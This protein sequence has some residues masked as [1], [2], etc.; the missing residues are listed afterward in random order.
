MSSIASVER[1]QHEAEQASTA[2]RR[3]PH[4][5]TYSRKWAAALFLVDLTLF[6]ASAYLAHLLA[7]RVWHTPNVAKQVTGAAIIIALWMVMFQ[8]LGLYRRTYAFRMRDELYYT[9]A[10]LSLGA[11]PQLLVFTVAPHISTSRVGALLTLALS[12]P[13]VGSGRAVM[14]GLRGLRIFKRASRIAFIG[15][16]HRTAEAVASIE[17]PAGPAP[18]VIAVED[19]NSTLRGEHGQ[20]IR[21][22]ESLEWFAQAMRSGCGTL[23]F[24]EIIDPQLLPHLLDVAARYR[25]RV[26]FAPPR[27]KWE[28]YSLSLEA[29]GSQALIVASPLNA[30]TPSARLT[31]RAIDVALAA[32]ALIVFAP[33]M[34]VCAIAVYL[35]SGA[36][37]LYRQERIGMDGKPFAILKFRSMAL[38][39]EKTTGA[40]WVREND[41]R[42]TRV[43]AIL[44]RL[45]F[46]ELPQ[47]FNVLRGEMSLVGP[48]PERP[49]F[50]EEFRKRFP[51]YDERHLVPPG[52]T[53]WSHVHM[54]R[55]VHEDDIGERLQYDL[56][57]VEQW[58]VWLDAAILFKT[59]VEFLFHKS[60]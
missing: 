7:Q 21:R 33:L 50:V 34:A 38:D 59:A 54:Q 13:M 25:L 44:R 9:I 56:R 46:D 12:I 24:T 5:I 29:N 26:A 32:V 49:V 45:S 4:A 42:R 57:Y 1:H 39:A 16:P 40:I 23:A 10:A 3:V 43:G 14:Y 36:P 22:L 19:V 35:E 2:A 20:P 53:G 27:I 30:C 8:L 28:A 41:D 11:M 18:F 6:V 58:T 17:V 52:I 55:L 60:V 48:R 31:K 15:T 47:F 51:R 37:V